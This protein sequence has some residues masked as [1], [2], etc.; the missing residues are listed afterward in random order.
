MLGHDLVE[1]FFLSLLPS[2]FR[3][4]EILLN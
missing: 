1:I 3:Q 2:L 4:S